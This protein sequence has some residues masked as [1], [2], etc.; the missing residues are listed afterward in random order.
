MR[1]EHCGGELRECACLSVRAGPCTCMACG[2]GD[3]LPPFGKTRPVPH[4]AS[5]CRDVLA[6]EVA[7]LKLLV[8]GQDELLVAYRLGSR[9]K[10]STFRKLER[11]RRPP[12]KKP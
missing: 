11:A 4:D 2:Q 5:E 6:R 8:E 12:E 10:E 1:C 3:P 7:R 9:P